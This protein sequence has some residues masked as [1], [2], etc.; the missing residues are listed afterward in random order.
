MK[1][2]IINGSPR[3]NGVTATLICELKKYLLGDIKVV[4]T[5]YAGIS[6]CMDCR[7]CWAHTGCAIQDDMQRIYQAINDADNIVIASPIYF[8]ELTGSLLQWASRLQYLWVSKQFRHEA[9]LND[10]PRNGGIILVD[11]G[12]GY[13][14]TAFAM[15]KRLLH[16]M[17]AEYKE[18]VYFSGT[19][20]TGAT[21]P[22]D[23]QTTMES[24]YRLA[25]TLNE[26][27]S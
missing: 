27:S 18:L 8:A 9:V 23:D 1:T 19:D 11:G 7:Y 21:S 22:K 4:D 3:K 2:L 6:P 16:N 26:K 20:Y 5:Y 12:D 17:G 13:M 14:E 24:I 15:A 10:K 25:K